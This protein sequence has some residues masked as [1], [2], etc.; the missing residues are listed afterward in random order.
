[1]GNFIENLYIGQKFGETPIAR[2]FIRLGYNVL[3]VYEKVY[4]EYKGPTLLAADGCEYILPDML[5]FNKEKS[6]FIEAKYKTT[7]TWYRI[8]NQWETGIDLHHYEQYRRIAEKS[9]WPVYILFLHAGGCDKDTGKKSP[10]GLYGAL[11]DDLTKCESHRSMNWGKA[12]MVYWC[13]DVLTKYA[14]YDELVAQ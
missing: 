1:M 12:G 8:K 3:L 13:I 9:A 6:F 11:L 4:T 10:A 2:W 14:D 7:F 5:C